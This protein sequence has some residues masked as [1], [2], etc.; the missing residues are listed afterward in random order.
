MQVLLYS[1]AS[2]VAFTSPKYLPL[3]CDSE[4]LPNAHRQ[5]VTTFLESLISL[6]SPPTKIPVSADKA[7][8]LRSAL[9]PVR[10]T[11]L[12]LS[13]IGRGQ[14]PY[15]TDH[16]PSLSPPLGQKRYVGR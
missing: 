16:I 9:K 5:V 3:Y 1:V 2:S 7:T 8:S 4:T 12:E 11:P 14:P 13:P 15:V 10:F 6:N